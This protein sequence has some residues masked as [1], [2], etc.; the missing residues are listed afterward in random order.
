MDGD[1]VQRRSLE[2]L[3]EEERIRRLNDRMLRDAS[4]G[5]ELAREKRARSVAGEAREKIRQL[6]GRLSLSSPG[7]I[8]DAVMK[9]EEDVERRRRETIRSIWVARG[10]PASNEAKAPSLSTPATTNGIRGTS[11]PAPQ[12]AK[13]K[14]TAPTGGGGGGRGDVAALESLSQSLE[15]ISVKGVVDFRNLANVPPAVEAIAAAT[16]CMVAHIDDPGDDPPYTVTTWGQIQKVL[17]KP[18]HFI[19]SLRRFPYAVNA[20]R[21]PESNIAEARLCLEQPAGDEKCLA[22]V[23]PVA[24]H[25]QHWLAAAFDYWASRRVTETSPHSA[26]PVRSVR[27]PE[28]TITTPSNA[29]TA[30]RNS[31]QPGGSQSSLSGVA[32][33]QSPKTVREQ[34]VSSPSKVQAS[35][36]PKMAN[37]RTSP[38]FSSGTARPK[39]TGGPVPNGQSSNVRS[40]GASGGYPSTTGVP[41]R[42]RQPATATG[43]A[44]LRNATSPSPTANATS[45]PGRSMQSAPRAATRATPTPNGAPATRSPAANGTSP[46]RG[47]STER[48]STLAKPRNPGSTQSAHQLTEQARARTPNSNRPKSPGTL[49]SRTSPSQMRASAPRVSNSKS[50]VGIQEWQ[51]QLDQ[52]KKEVREIRALEKQL[53]WGMV[54]EEKKEAIEE[55]KEAER[56]IRE[57]RWQQKDEMDEYVE[58][59]HKDQLYNDLLASR[60][61]QEWKRECRQIDKDATLAYIQESYQNSQ[62]FSQWQAELAR[63][64]QEEKK[65]MVQEHYERYDMERERRAQEKALEQAEEVQERTLARQLEMDHASKELAREK[66]ALL[67]SLEFTRARQTAPIHVGGNKSTSRLL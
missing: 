26:E 48:T 43:A 66:E 15:Q 23:H 8:A 9:L 67:R 42:L 36:P 38:G 27:P 65:S 24:F 10:G 33:Q 63:S 51:R 62:E 39:S 34:G 19:N 30:A 29:P 47:A 22:Q 50:D 49:A 57:W 25:L 45:T 56:E 35:P 60:E 31:P 64:I 46:R 21:V 20:G 37:G 1:A 13:A 32:R 40:P 3:C 6:N 54:R 28:K 11:T 18:G 4:Q 5:A 53:K 2:I 12:N 44:R 7:E 17:C 59:K 55:K 41:S 16:F 58:A 14:P 52:T 61:F